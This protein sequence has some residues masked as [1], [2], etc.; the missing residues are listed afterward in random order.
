MVH[1]IRS[2]FENDVK[3][4]GTETMLMLSCSTLLFENDVKTYGTE[5]EDNPASI[6]VRFEN[7]V[8]TYDT[9]TPRTHSHSLYR[10]RMM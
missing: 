10:L 7:D 9:E 1:L 6:P 4:Y 2:K 5:T 3:T 8:K